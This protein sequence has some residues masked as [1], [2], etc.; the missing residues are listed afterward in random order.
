MDAVPVQVAFEFLLEPA[1]NN[2][3][4]YP[5]AMS[6][7]LRRIWM[8]GKQPRLR[9]NSLGNVPWDESLYFRY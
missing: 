6:K 3:P 8:D 7:I 4:T 5:I 1:L 9:C 2:Q